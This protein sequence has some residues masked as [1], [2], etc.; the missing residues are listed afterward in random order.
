MEARKCLVVKESLNAINFNHEYLEKYSRA[1]VRKSYTQV[2]HLFLKKLMES[3]ILTGDEFKLPCYMGSLQFVKVKAN[4]RFRTIDW[5]M[6]KEVYGE[7]NKT[8]P[9]EQR[10]LCVHAFN[11][12]PG[13]YV[14]LHWSKSKFTNIFRNNK[15]YSFSMSRTWFRHDESST[16]KRKSIHVL[17]Q[18]R[19]HGFGRYKTLVRFKRQEI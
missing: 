17:D 2:V 5:Q 4:K 18:I 1:Y 16:A 6:T 12:T 14:K 13:Y 11:L 9:K 7:Y 19:D 8:V 10:K 3:L 15:F